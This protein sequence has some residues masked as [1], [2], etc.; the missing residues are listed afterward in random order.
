[1]P[2][3]EKIPEGICLVGDVWLNAQ[4]EPLPKDEQEFYNLDILEI[5]PPPKAEKQK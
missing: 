2:F 5:Q 1:M 4:G 3:Y